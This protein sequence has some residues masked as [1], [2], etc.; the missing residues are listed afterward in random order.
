MVRTLN[1]G[2]LAHVDAGKTSLTER[3]L[4]EVGVIRTIGS[5]DA[6]S[7]HTDSLDLERQRGITIK[8]AVVSFE[9]NGV[10]VNLIDTP[11]HPDF[12]AEVERVLNVLDGAVLVIS[13]VEGVQS[14]TRILMRALQRLELPT[15]MFVNKIDRAGARGADLVQEIAARLAPAVVPMGTVNRRGTRTAAFLPY[16]DADDAL[17]S[18]MLD[19]LVDDDDELLAAFVED[20]TTISSERLIA[21][22]GARIRAASLHPIFFGSA[23][24][25]AGIRPLIDGITA[26][27]PAAESDPNLS[28][29]GAIFKIERGPVG[30]KVA[31][32]RMFT[33][34]LH[35]RDRPS[36]GR[37]TDEKVVGLQVF[38]AGRSVQRTALHAG[39]IG[40]L[41]GLKDARL[42]D[43]FGDVPIALTRRHFAP[44]TLETVI[45][46]RD[47]GE[48]GALFAALT[49]LAEQDPLIN[50]RSNE[51]HD[52]LYVSLYGEVQKEVIEATLAVEF[53][54]AVEFRET[55]T[56]CVERP[57]GTGTAYAEIAK[58][59]NPFLATVGLR[60]EPGEIGSGV[61]FRRAQQVLGTLP[62]AFFAATEEAVHDT[63]QQGLAGWQ[64]TD[65]VVTMT[66]TG[67]WARQSSA[68]GGFDKS[69]SSTAGDFRN[70]TPLLLMEALQ[71]ATTEVCEPLHHFRLEVPS[72]VLG[73]VLAALARV[74]ALPDPPVMLPS[75]C[76]IE[77]EVPADQVH[78]L[79]QALPRLSRGEGLFECEF[80]R[81][82]AVIGTVPS[83]PRTD[84]NPLHREEYLLN[85]TRRLGT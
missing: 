64:V 24:T 7:T 81:Y 69:M 73:S 68:H 67:Y 9:V 84:N 80:A 56:I 70:L 35:A 54:V 50:V 37:E 49:T 18:R 61:V 55:T 74:G 34:T 11:G 10:S 48:R 39:Q 12:I 22:F 40:K 43:T 26:Y 27:L 66:H 57:L 77:G 63:L 4:Y 36:F 79:Q 47:A 16:T 25:G 3:L 31:Y 21:G 15:L 65:C 76:V 29:A 52:E 33:G 85:L 42:G 14:Q 62:P 53:G 45:R 60:V 83:R 59:P 82:R 2:I 75:S 71:Q 78:G 6:G 23:I 72:D 32:A 20:D 38:E 30:E 5:V 51:Q 41:W 28:P 44:P 1:L 8:S 58:D 46:P 13:A 19:V 17:R